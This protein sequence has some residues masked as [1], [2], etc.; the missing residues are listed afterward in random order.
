MEG[1]SGDQQAQTAINVAKAQIASGDPV[2]A[3]QV[4]QPA[5]AEQVKACD[6]LLK[7]QKCVQSLLQLLQSTGGIDAAVPALQRYSAVHFH[8]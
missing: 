1:G 4:R 3:L 8:C 6:G 2:A 7:V 5:S